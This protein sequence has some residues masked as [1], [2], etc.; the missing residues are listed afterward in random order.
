MNKCLLNQKYFHIIKKKAMNPHK[1]LALHITDPKTQ[2]ICTACGTRYSSKKF[3]KHECPIC[4]D[5]RQYVPSDGQTWLSFQSLEADYSIEIKKH[6]EQLFEMSVLPDFA[7]G[8]RA[9][10]LQS[11]AGNMLWDCIPLITQSAVDFIQDRG[12]IQ[13]IAISH[14]HYYSLMA[15][16]ASAFQCPIYLHQGDHQ[17]IMDGHQHVHFWE[18]KEKRL[19]DRFTL[20]HTGGHFPGSTV[21]HTDIAKL[22]PTLFTGD[23]LYLSKDLR[24]LSTMYSYPNFVPLSRTETLGVFEA[25]ANYPSE[26]IMGAFPHQNMYSNGKKIIADSFKRYKYAFEN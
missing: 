16:W 10:F 2:N 14:P 11:E 26:A 7:I 20:V 24:H 19:M 13:A 22:G 21:L 18:G 17:W 9:F 12:G 1:S 8:Q 23:S 5:D 3:R 4:L 15:E 25:V 6:T